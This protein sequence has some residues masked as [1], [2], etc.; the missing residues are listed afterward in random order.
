MEKPQA[1]RS[2][3]GRATLDKQIRGSQNMATSQS[4]TLG[5][6]IGAFFEDLMKKPIRDFAVRNG[7]Y[8]DSFGVRKARDS[9]KVTWVDIHGSKHDLDFVIEKGGSDDQMGEPVAFIELAWRRYTKHSK[10]KAQEIS[11]AVDPICENYKMQKPFKGAILSG[12]FTDSAIQQLKDDDFHVLYIP[13]EKIVS[14]FSLHGLDIDYGEST[15]ESEIR[16]KFTA[17]SKK[18]NRMLI[19]AVRNTL[20]R[21][22]RREISRFVSELTAS[23]RRKIKTICILPLHGKRTEMAD[24][25]SAINFLNGYA[26]IPLG[27]RLEYI[28]IVVIYNTGTRIHGQFK[29]RAEAV[30]FLT[31][32]Q[33]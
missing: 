30:E 12:Q 24:V 10:N 2:V 6:F 26:R 33:D 21:D 27:A 16:K 28:E 1:S 25:V 32:I 18:S 23:Y 3:K 8:F 19:E 20:L 11:G 4:H 5:E 9:K 14:A 15:R 7:L 31:H 17:V 22:C 29:E 13:F